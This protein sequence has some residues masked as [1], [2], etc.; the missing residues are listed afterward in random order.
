MFLVAVGRAKFTFVVLVHLFHRLKEA[1][2]AVLYLVDLH[3][4]RLQDLRGNSFA[5]AQQ[6]QQQVFGAHHLL[7]HRV[8]LG[9]R[10][11]QHLLGARRVGQVTLGLDVT[12][13]PHHTLDRDAH[14][15]Q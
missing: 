2:H 4:Q 15:V 10:K 13:E 11:L 1:A 12:A 9:N 6:R 3:I 7:P 5:L 8:R 14:I